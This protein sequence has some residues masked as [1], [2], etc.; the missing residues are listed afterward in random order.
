MN[1][2][3]SS[4]LNTA[5]AASSTGDTPKN[6]TI[7][8]QE[9][10]KLFITQLQHQDPSSPLS[11]DQLTAQL[12]QF[13]SLEQLTGVNTRLDTLANLSHDQGS[14][15][16]VGLIGKQVTIDGDH[17]AVKTGQAPEVEYTVADDKADKVSATI[18]DDSGK[19]VRVVDLGK[20]GKGDHSFV[21]DGKN[22]LDTVVPDGTYSITI[23]ATAI[24]APAPTQLPLLTKAPVD[25]VDF[26]VDPPQLLVG[27]IHVTLDRVHDVRTSST[28][29]E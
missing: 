1:V 15:A 14:S 6:Q 20:Q 16:L 2:A 13:A 4:L 7:N 28:A 11:P 24:G 21:W 22:S 9:F 5:A 18:R 17:V 8:Q 29:K 25:G 26:S 27:G 3:P 19:A 23:S 10:L 12:A